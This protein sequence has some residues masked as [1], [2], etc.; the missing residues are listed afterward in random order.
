MD[1][2]WVKDLI[3]NKNAQE[4]VRNKKF[5]GLAQRLMKSRKLT[6]KYVGKS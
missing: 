4:C 5:S 2:S 6:I 1:G 3:L